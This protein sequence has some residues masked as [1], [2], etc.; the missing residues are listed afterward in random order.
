LREQLGGENEVISELIDAFLSNTPNRLRNLE[1]AFQN[2][3]TD[4]LGKIA[5]SLRSASATLGALNMSQL[6]VALEEGSAQD[7]SALASPIEALNMEFLRVKARLIEFRRTSIPE[8][9]G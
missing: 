9:A 6:C 5:H 1:T 4:A 2:G 8:R 7:G 3:N